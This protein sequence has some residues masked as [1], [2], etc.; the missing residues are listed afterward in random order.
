MYNV[1]VGALFCLLAWAVYYVVLVVLEPFL[2]PLFWAGLTGFVI[3]PYKT[4]FT[5][6]LR[7]W[8]TGLEE[9]EKPAF[10][11]ICVDFVNLID[12]SCHSIGSKIL[13]KW[14]LMVVLMI[15]YPIYH[16]VTFYPLDVTT[17]V[18]ISK[19][20]RTF[21]IVEFVTWPIV[22]SSSIAYAISVLVLWKD[23]RRIIFQVFGCFLWAMIALY[24]INLFWP[25]LWM[26]TLLGILFYAL[27][28]ISS[29]LSGMLCKTT[30][31]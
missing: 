30:L 13:S 5:E 21:E 8:L 4:T 9:Q 25:P 15:S 19:I 17:P 23:E 31:K 18:I 16:Y 10:I 6:F 20:W 1:I 2:L 14:K 27:S 7:N 28:K 11:A 29:K 3:H 22:A 26:V 12:W 24:I